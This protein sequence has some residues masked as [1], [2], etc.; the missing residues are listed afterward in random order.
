MRTLYLGLNPPAEL[1]GQS[2][3][4]YPVIRVEPA[5][6]ELP[7]E[8]SHVIFTS[9]T[10]V[11]IV[12][13]NLKNDVHIYAVGKATADAARQAGLYVR[14][15]ATPETAEGMVTLLQQQ[16]LSHAKIFWPRSAL[17]R[18]L[19]SD[20]CRDA[21][22]ALVDIC[23][24][25]THLIKPT[26]LPALCDFDEVVFT[27]PSTVDGFFAIYA[28]FP[29]HLKVRVIGPV[30]KNYLMKKMDIIDTMDRMDIM[31]LR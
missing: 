21:K 19:I 14:A 15:I 17:A 16:N 28:T 24:Y 8:Y 7:D 27:S 12:A 11:N 9:K 3:V 25:S 10:A 22:I 13:G 2:I 4:H 20:Y 26:P 23:V 31:D 30:T 29:S 1:P 5:S 18:T 6:F